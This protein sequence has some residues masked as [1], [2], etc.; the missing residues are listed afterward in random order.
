MIRTW[1]LPSCTFFSPFVGCFVLLTIGKFSFQNDLERHN[2]E[3][4]KMWSMRVWHVHWW[5]IQKQWPKWTSIC[6]EGKRGVSAIPEA[7]FSQ[8]IFRLQREPCYT[9]SSPHCW[10]RNLFFS[11]GNTTL[12]ADFSGS[13]ATRIAK[14]ARLGSCSLVHRGTLCTWMDGVWLR[15]TFSL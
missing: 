15:N 14:L 4:H 8:L 3:L 5:M 11:P 9:G 12:V 7:W 2:T 6:K 13:V 1:V 10:H